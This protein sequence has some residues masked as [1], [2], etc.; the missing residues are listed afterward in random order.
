[1]PNYSKE[2]GKINTMNLRNGRDT[3]R[4]TLSSAAIVAVAT[5]SA[6]PTRAQTGA[7]AE[8]DSGLVLEEIT[9]TARKREEST[10]DVPITVAA[11]SGQE[12][13]KVGVTSMVQLTQSVPGVYFASFGAGQPVVSMRGNVNRLSG[14]PGVGFFTDGVYTANSAQFS[15]GPVDAA[16]VEVLQGPQGTVYGKNTIA[17]AIN[18]ITNNPTSTF[19][20]L[21]SSGYGGSSQSRDS[22]WHA[23]GVVSGP[24]TDTLEG[25]LVYKHNERDG[26]LYD[27]IS[28]VRLGGSEADY[29]RGKLQWRPTDRTT[30]RL[31]AEY[32]SANV[33]RYEAFQNFPSA[34][35]PFMGSTPVELWFPGQSGPFYEIRAQAGRELF[36][37]AKQSRAYLEVSQETGIGTIT[38]QTSYA[39]AEFT[40]LQDADIGAAQLV[41]LEIDRDNLA[42]SQELRLAG[43]EGGWTWLGG[44]YYLYDYTEDLLDQIFY[45]LS[46][47]YQGGLARQ[48]N[49]HELTTDSYAAFAQVGYEITPKLQTTI[50]FRWARDDKDSPMVAS[51]IA[52]SGAVNSV[53]AQRNDTWDS[54]TYLVSLNYNWTDEIMTYAS[55][56]TGFKSGGFQQAANLNVATTYYDPETVGQ[57]EIGLKSDLFGR[58]LRL[59]VSAYH[60]KYKDLQ[61]NNLRFF[62]TTP[63]Q[64]ISNAAG[65]KVVGADLELKALLN[66][67]FTLTLAETYLPTAK[68]VGFSSLGGF[69]SIEGFRMPRSPKHSFTASLDFSKELAN[70]LTL[71]FGASYAY[72]SDFVNE[73][74]A[75]LKPDGSYSTIPLPGYGLV[76]L[77]ASATYGAWDIS[78]YMRN[79]TDKEYFTSATNGG[80]GRNL[81]P[82]TWGEPRTWE[83][84][85]AYRF[86]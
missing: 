23:L 47:F 44:A 74:D 24:L 13:D 72:R 31:T 56:S 77:T 60:L 8:G 36:S 50:G 75:V 42:Y 65:A 67:N 16:R 2:S 64:L 5:F 61:V 30:V 71:G 4:Y 86:E 85:L 34:V 18:I 82:L 57:S 35:H 70:E 27:P 81:F 84:S 7:G 59:N 76:G 73:L 15:H 63:V 11:I 17:G 37:K 52:P 26:Y 43:A 55:Y 62:G 1:L 48:P 9:V 78:F 45:P 6:G 22:L 69:P 33:P 10:Q 38:S 19:E 51:L 28:G 68:I 66:E 29:A 3:V 32:E 58:R 14:T 80:A 54:N 46:R 25:R 79:V 40:Q 53:V 12:L 83:V 20:G 49:Y 41:D 21:A 39:E